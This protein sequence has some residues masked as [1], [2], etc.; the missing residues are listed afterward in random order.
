VLYVLFGLLAG[1]AWALFFILRF[2]IWIPIGVSAAAVIAMVVTFVVKRMAASRRADALEK[3]LANQGQQQAMNANPARRGEIQ[4]LQKQIS[5]GIT[6]LKS[7]RLGGKRKGKNALYAL[8]WYAIIGPP[9][10]GKTTALRHSGLV[11]PYADSAVRGVGGTRNCDWWFTNEAILLDTAGRYATE[12]ADAQEW[13]AFLDLLRKYRGDKPLNGLIIAVAAVEIIDATEPM[14]EQM[15]Q[16]L[17]ARIDEVMTRLGMVLPVYL[18]VTKCDLMAGFTEFFG[19]MKK[20][21]RAQAWG[22]TFNLN[23]DK[24]NPGAIFTREFDILVQSVH[25]RSLGRLANERD[26]GARELIYQFPLEFAALR[27]PLND[28]VGRVFAPNNFG[29]TPTFR[30]F[31]FTSGTQEGLPL[32]RVLMRMGQAMGIRHMQAFGNQPASESKSYFLHDVFMTV[33]FPDAEVASRSP[34]EIRRQKI[35]RFGV[36]AAA[37]AVA[38]T[39]CVPSIVSYFNNQALL[40]D[41]EA[42]AKKAARIEWKGKAQITEKVDQLRPLLDRLKELDEN[43]QKGVPFGYGFLMYSGEDVRAPVLGLFL[44]NMQKG[45]VQTCKFHL[46]DRL[47]NATGERFY[48][49]YLLLRTYLQLS[50]VEHLDVEWATGVYSTLWAELTSDNA[51]ESLYD[52]K[53]RVEPLVRYYFELIK[54]TKERPARADP[55]AANEKIVEHARTVLAKAAPPARYHAILIESLK[56]ETFD[57]L[58]EL[59]GGNQQYPPVGLTD[60][61]ADKAPALTVIDSKKHKEENK[62]FR[63]EGIYTDRGHYAVLVNLA[64]AKQILRD[65]SW[66]LPLTKQEKDGDI[67]SALNT[68]AKDYETAYIAAWRA[69]AADLLLQPPANLKEAAALYKVLLEPER[70]YIRLI[71]GFEDNTQ[72][73]RDLEKLAEMRLTQF[74]D[75][76][77][78]FN[79]EAERRVRG[80][81]LK[82]DPFKIQN[83]KSRVPGAFEPL[84]RFGVAARGKPI[85]DTPL[86]QWGDTVEELRKLIL[87]QLDTLPD[88]TVETMSEQI[89]TAIKAT[90]SLLQGLDEPTRAALRPLLMTPLNIGGKFGS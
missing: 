3:A 13:L 27:R 42:R 68:V 10:A 53:Q 20:S 66:V 88:S 60:I 54:P 77:P 44:A 1:L 50:D 12:S 40:D 2:L 8:P 49:D 19:T 7:S 11:F 29:Q 22:A 58:A 56:Y 74:G 33:V 89:K 36:G 6:A 52:Q 17:R 4:A 80:K 90:E 64:E 71:R 39:F 69:F 37:L 23:E 43:E 41:T 78:K 21:E 9:G 87:K 51:K 24:S 26:R 48:E 47:K 70:P 16:K 38:L 32:N 72:F 62:W 55:V 63:V 83:E 61:F 57:P 34:A 65:Q 67:Q 25:G 75:T 5:D 15:A 45:F 35:L 82:I 84:V 86:A 79:S 14:L 73:T 31:Y 59:V 85:G 46:E 30:G 81:E 76:P 28:L 18:V